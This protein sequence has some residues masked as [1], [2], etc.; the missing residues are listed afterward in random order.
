MAE[1]KIE[2]K[3]PIW[4]WIILVLVIL[5]LLYFLVFA[6]D[7]DTDD[8]MDDMNTEQVEEETAWEED[9]DTADWEQSQADWK[10]DSLGTGTVAGYMAYVSDKSKMGVDHEYTNNALQHLINAVQAKADEMNYDISADMKEVKQSAQKIIEDP[11]AATHANTIK[12]AG[13]KLANILQKMQKENYVDLSKDVEEVKTAA[14]NIK[15][16]VQTLQQKDQINKFFDEAADVLSK[17]N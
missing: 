10:N 14:N 12:E 9:T 1:I 3:K 17:M 16:D 6:N 5:A 8:D 15:P 2:K 7:D 11:T 4:P 13:T